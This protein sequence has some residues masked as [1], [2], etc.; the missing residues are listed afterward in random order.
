[1]NGSARAPFFT[2]RNETSFLT[3]HQFD[4][5][6]VLPIAPSQQFAG[7]FLLPTTIPLSLLY[8]LDTQH[9]LMNES[10]FVTLML[11][12]VVR[13][14]ALKWNISIDHNFMACALSHDYTLLHNVFVSNKN[15]FDRC[16]WPTKRFFWHI[17]IILFGHKMPFTTILL[18]QSP[19]NRASSKLCVQRV[20]FFFQTEFG[21]E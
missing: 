3:R 14:R 12:P 13:K 1:M 7:K 15:K 11:C 18:W 6:M 5:D 4:Y 19:K 17:S 8:L 16:W 21:L 9:K 20:V 2:L 10:M